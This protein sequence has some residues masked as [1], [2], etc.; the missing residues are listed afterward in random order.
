MIPINQPI[1]V[2]L[3]RPSAH[4]TVT[5]MFTGQLV[6]QMRNFY[7][8]YGFLSTYKGNHVRQ[9]NSR[10][11]LPRLPPYQRRGYQSIRQAMYC[12]VLG[13][14]CQTIKLILINEWLFQP[15]VRCGKCDRSIATIFTMPH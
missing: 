13:G 9:A 7:L 6:A 5:D 15:R 3:A 1:L 14:K 10:F 4:N 8:R 12:Y 11:R 2:C